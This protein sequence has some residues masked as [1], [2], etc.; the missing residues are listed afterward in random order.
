MWC[1]FTY[2]LHVNNSDDPGVAQHAGQFWS[3]KVLLQTPLMMLA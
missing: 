3:G 2:S 1:F